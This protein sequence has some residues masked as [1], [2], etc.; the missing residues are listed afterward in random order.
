MDKLLGTS[1]FTY[2]PAAKINGLG[3]ISD[4]T[5]PSPFSV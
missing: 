1:S 2:S 5:L 3:G 4:F